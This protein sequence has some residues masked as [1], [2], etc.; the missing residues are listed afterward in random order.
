MLSASSQHSIVARKDEDCTANFKIFG[1]KLKSA[2]TLRI[3][4]NEVFPHKNAAHPTA[5]FVFTEVSTVERPQ[6][7]TSV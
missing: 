5:T 7:L 1:G 3:S 6:L 4:R 2:L